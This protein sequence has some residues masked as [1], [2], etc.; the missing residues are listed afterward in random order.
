M[1]ALPNAITG[2]QVSAHPEPEDVAEAATAK[3]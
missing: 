1:I 2:W 3:M